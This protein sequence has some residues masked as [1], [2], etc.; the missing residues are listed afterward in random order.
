VLFTH[1]IICDEYPV[2]VELPADKYNLPAERPVAA[3]AG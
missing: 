2:S 1:Y 3:A